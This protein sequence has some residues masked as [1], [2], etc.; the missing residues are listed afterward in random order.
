MFPD[1]EAQL[2][3]IAVFAVNNKNNLCQIGSYCY[4]HR[5]TDPP[6]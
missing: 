4:A 3:G 2:L 5:K 6:G 1:W